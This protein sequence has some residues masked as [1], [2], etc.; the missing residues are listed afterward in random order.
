MYFNGQQ[1]YKLIGQI[2]ACTLHYRRTSAA[3]KLG[4]DTDATLMSPKDAQHYI[5]WQHATYLLP[6]IIYSELNNKKVDGD[7]ST[8]PKHGTRIKNK[9]RFDPIHDFTPKPDM[10]QRL[11][12]ASSV[13]EL[14]S[15][16]YPSYWATLKCRSK[17]FA[18]AASS[19]SKLTQWPQPHR[20]RPLADTEEPKFAAAYLNLDVLK[21]TNVSC[22]QNARSRSLMPCPELVFPRFSHLPL[23]RQVR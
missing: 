22:R 12:S 5:N 3:K 18:A 20:L 21:S 2:D 15:L 1:H 19:A 9:D 10:E 8:G 13:D 16:I 23:C 6:L 14:M 17:L 11:R 4:E 7:A